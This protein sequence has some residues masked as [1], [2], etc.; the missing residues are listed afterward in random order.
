MG[1]ATGLQ[2]LVRGGLGV[3]AGIHLGAL[4]CGR[5]G[6]DSFVLLWE[7]SIMPAGF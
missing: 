6:L 4:L 1:W 3:A 2:A 7:G 5:L